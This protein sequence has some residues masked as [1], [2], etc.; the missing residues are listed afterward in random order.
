MFPLLY[1]LLPNRT[2]E[3]YGR[4]V[5]SIQ[6]AAIENDVQFDPDTIMVDYEV[7]SIQAYQQALPRTT[8]KGCLFHYGQCI[9]RGIKRVGLEGAYR[10][11]DLGSPLRRMVRRTSAL[12][13]VPPDQLD[14]IW[15]NIV[16]DAPANP[17]IPEFQ[18]YFENTWIGNGARFD[19]NLWNHYDCI[20]ESRTINALE[21]WHHKVNLYLGKAH[22]NIWESLLWLRKKELFQRVELQRLEAGGVPNPRRLAYVRV[23]NRLN[24]LK[25]QYQNGQRNV[26]NYLDAVSH[27]L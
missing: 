5:N 19:R 23:D 9:Q 18:E 6:A 12:P 14:F 25:L 20:T 16:T 17:E 13:L 4:F 2:E 21:G 3:T 15:G 22:P 8:I 10:A 27:L 1:G 11:A 24:N 26:M 7:A